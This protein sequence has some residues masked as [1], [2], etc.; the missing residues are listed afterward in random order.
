LA[1]LISGQFGIWT[2]G[3]VCPPMWRQEREQEVPDKRQQAE[4]ESGEQQRRAEWDASA[5]WVK[6]NPATAERQLRLVEKEQ[7]E[8]PEHRVDIGAAADYWARNADRFAKA[9]QSA[10]SAARFEEIRTRL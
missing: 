4:W 7:I 5:S 3:G 9:I 8:D 2:K 10:Q 1:Q 6:Q